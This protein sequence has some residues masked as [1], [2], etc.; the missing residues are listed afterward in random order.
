M[1]DDTANNGD[2]NFRETNGVDI[3]VGANN[4]GY[5]IGWTREGEWLEYTINVQQNGLYNFDFATASQ[6]GTGVLGV[7]I[8]GN[9][10]LTGIEVPQTGGWDDYAFFTQTAELTSGEHVL[11]FKV[12]NGGFNIDKIN[13]SDN[14]LSTD[15]FTKRTLAIHPNPSRT[16]IFNLPSK[17]DFKVYA[18]N[19]KLLLKAYSDQADLSQLPKGIYFLSTENRGFAKLVK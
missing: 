19:G 14:S 5:A 17:M 7:D 15:G 1:D 18:I 4:T 10:L 3:G 16:G 13:I 9:A 8:D 11:R 12:E 6:N 2:V